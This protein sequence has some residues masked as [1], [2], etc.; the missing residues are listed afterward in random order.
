MR[1]FW[2]RFQVFLLTTFHQRLGRTYVV[3]AGTAIV[4]AGFVRRSKEVGPHAVVSG[5]VLIASGA[6]LPYLRRIKAGPVEADLGLDP[7]LAEVAIDASHGT[8]DEV[9]SS[10]RQ[11]LVRLRYEASEAAMREL[12][13]PTEALDG[14]AFR[15][16]VYDDELGRL[17][18][19]F[20]TED[21]GEEPHGWRPGR[22]VTGQCYVH[23]EYVAAV[24]E[25]THSADYGLTLAEQRRYAN[26]AAVASVPVRD[27]SGAV[28]AV[29]SAST[30]D[31]TTRL[32]AKQGLDQ[33]I[34]LAS[35]ISRVL[36][37]LLQLF[38]DPVA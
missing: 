7:A 23:G 20:Q 38:A 29:L 16:Y 4:A 26:L 17:L 35:L 3:L 15:V 18:P 25:E 2:W 30:T 22:G 10:Q 21:S 32:L 31:P 28:I 19:I 12:L 5:A 36:I 9:P 8:I 13:R 14:C 34:H 11:L 24:G 6:L 33:H 1:R 37:D 27:A